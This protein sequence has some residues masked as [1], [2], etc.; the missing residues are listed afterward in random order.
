MTVST[1]FRSIPLLLAL[2][3]APLAAQ[4]DHHPV[5][6]ERAVRRSLP[7]PPM[8]RRAYAAGTRDSTTGVPGPNYWQQS[9]DYRIDATLDVQNAVLH[10]RETIAF[11]NTSPDTLT[12][13]ILRLYQNYFTAKESRDDYVTDITD[14]MVMERLA[15]DSVR[16]ALDDPRSYRVDGTI[17]T[18]HL[19][20]PLLPGATATIQARWHF[21][22]PNVPLGERGER[23]GRWGKDLYQIAQWYPQV[24]MFDDL[25]GWDT[26]QYLGI[27]EFYNQFGRFDV[28]LTLP[29]G[30]LVGATGTLAN[31][32]SVL[33]PMVRTRLALAMTADTTVHV[34]T[35]AE[36]GAGSATLNGQSLTW[37]FTAPRVN[38][39]AF[40]ASRSF[41]Y[42][43]THAMAPKPTLVQVLYLPEHTDYRQSAQYARFALEHH[44]RY[45]M[46][47]DF[48]QATVADGP[49]TGMEYPM[50]IFSGPG[51][52]VI[53]HEL[54]HQW[55]P[56]MVSSNE[57]WYGWQDEGLNEYIDAAAGADFT[58]R[59]PDHMRD[60]ADYRRVAG[61]ALE[62]ALMWPSDYAGPDYTVQAYVKTPLALYA[63]GGVVGD[64]AVH[65]AFAAYARAWR[66]KHP[67]PWDFFTFMQHRLGRNLGWFWNAWW[68]TTE[69]FDQG[70]AR[71][72]ARSGRLT[73]TVDDRGSMAMPI[74]VRI[75]YTDSSSTTVTRPA[76]VWF[77]G[78]R[79]VTIQQTTGRK[80]VARVTLDPDN[81]FQDL[82]RSNNVWTAGTP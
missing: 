16:V 30:W 50:I 21:A 33:T 54:G 17:A 57:T 45:V 11:H 4:S 31:S 51:F 81:R 77:A 39:F 80:Q 82:D 35:A 73:F 53:T 66:Y 24:A 61:T 70:L 43:A 79:S 58:H 5:W 27:G 68:F 52:D 14:G 36:R 64:S 22:V 74:I 40:V 20:T 60:G 7:L 18:V 13:L 12:T 23:M 38:D 28:R 71:V 32:D 26:D 76:S 9:A 41:V 10:G 1:V 63:L 29:A 2:A 62:P 15:V 3:A 6:P 44:S 69:T 42:D 55:F 72:D 78:D 47:Y 46:P 56:M 48:P 67:S 75:D 34:V 37:H 59:P 19:R 25:R 8:I 65:T 49:E